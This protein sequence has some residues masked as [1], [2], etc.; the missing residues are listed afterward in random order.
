MTPQPYILP[1]VV[2]RPRIRTAEPRPRTRPRAGNVH[3]FELDPALKLTPKDLRRVDLAEWLKRR[4]AKH[5]RS[6]QRV[7]NDTVEDG[8][9]Y[10]MYRLDSNT[11]PTFTVPPGNGDDRTSGPATLVSQGCRISGL[12]TGDGNF[13]LAG[14][15]D[16]D[17]EFAGTVTLART[18][19]WR[20]TIRAGDVIVAGHVEGD[21][22]ADGHVEIADT[23]RINGTVSGRAIAVA[24]GA[25]VEGIMRT[26]GPSA[27]TEFVE[28]RATAPEPPD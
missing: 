22:V 12:V 23:A 17:C 6:Y 27:P 28:K 1:P 14:E 2:D 18:G 13:H 7:H 20:G 10:M 15:I 21:I 3:I 4:H 16:G 24:E 5:I 9:I 25:V 8:S 11:E 26:T 19:I